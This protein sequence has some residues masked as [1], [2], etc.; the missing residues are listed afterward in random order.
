M[1]VISIKP[2]P[3]NKRTNLNRFSELARG[4]FCTKWAIY[5]RKK[6]KLSPPIYLLILIV[7]L[8]GF[9]LIS[10]RLEYPANGDSIGYVHAA[11][12]L[13]EGRGLAH[14]DVNNSFAGPYFSPFAFQIRREIGP[15]LYL[16]YPPGFPLLLATTILLTASDAFI[17]FAYP[18][19]AIA[20][21]VFTFL[22]GWFVSKNRWTGLLAVIIVGTT[23]DFWQ[24]GTAPWSEIPSLALATIGILFFLFS[25]Q[26]QPKIFNKLVW[27]ILAALVL[28]FCLYVRYANIMLFLGLG[29]YEWVDGGVLFFK[30]KKRWPFWVGIGLFVVTILI[31]NNSYYGGYLR[32]SYHPENGWYFKAPFSL[33]Y[34]F[35]PPGFSFIKLVRTLWSNFSVLLLFAPVG[36]FLSKR[37]FGILLAGSSLGV[38]AIYA[39]YTFPTTG[40]NGRFILPTYSFIGIGIAVALM[41]L[42]QKIPRNWLKLTLSLVIL[43]LLIWPLPEKV[44]ELQGR[45]EQGEQLALRVQKISNAVEENAVLISHAA[46]DYIIFYGERSTLNSRRIPPPDAELGDFNYDLLEPCLVQTIDRLLVTDIPVYVL[47]N[48]S[49]P[50]EKSVYEILQANYTLGASLEGQPN[51]QP[52]HPISQ[53]VRESASCP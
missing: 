4:F 45:N 43:L 1:D 39:V 41:A 2:I 25:R 36:W 20:G 50:L 8:I 40:I 9:F 32:T 15:N 22:L 26:S 29:L 21:L 23:P 37:P 30:D 44:T 24:F 6:P 48:Q 12:G 13:A 52:I 7:G 27:S 19:F 42:F 49:V 51:L 31:F 16:G 28:G 18:I 53:S 17:S 3:R 11:R 35:G 34:A 10:L 38:I 47:Y 46:N 14:S 33:S 5:F